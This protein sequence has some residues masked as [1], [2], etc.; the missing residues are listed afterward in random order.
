MG[1]QISPLYDFLKGYY[2][3]HPFNYSMFQM[4]L[5]SAYACREHSNTDIAY[6]HTGEIHQES[7]P[8]LN[9]LYKHVHFSLEYCVL[10]RSTLTSYLESEEAVVAEVEALQIHEAAQAR[11][12]H[13]NQH[14]TAPHNTRM[15][16]HG[17]KKNTNRRGRGYTAPTSERAR[18]ERLSDVASV[19]A[20]PASRFACSTVSRAISS[21][22]GRRR[23]GG[24]SEASARCGGRRAELSSL[25]DFKREK[26]PNL[27]RAICSWHVGPTVSLH[28][29]F[30]S[31]LVREGG[32]AQETRNAGQSGRGE[33]GAPLE[34]GENFPRRGLRLLA[35]MAMTVEGEGRSEFPS[36]I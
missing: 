10:T 1:H 13:K 34:F 4:D 24:R 2:G 9:L 26:Y 19:P 17:R 22:S 32:K 33:G 35:E 8:M 3:I 21:S 29:V 20:D 16:K 18:W 11:H 23:W 30:L 6:I 14:S 15:R 7:T 36:P 28:G 12:L 5:P 25:K 27:T 31:L